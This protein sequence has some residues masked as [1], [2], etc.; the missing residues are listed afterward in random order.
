MDIQNVVQPDD[1][2]A[3]LQA[4]ENNH[5]IITRAISKFV[6]DYARMPTKTELSADTKLSRQTITAHMEEMAAV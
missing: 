6:E 5:T 2:G 4:W 3:K 1:A